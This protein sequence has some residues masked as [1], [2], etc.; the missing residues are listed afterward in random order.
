MVEPLGEQMDV[1][2][3]TTGGTPVVFRVPAHP[4]IDQDRALEL[5]VDTGRL[6]LFEPGEFGASLRGSG[7]DADAVGAATSGGSDG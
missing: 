2:G 1:H 3:D 4:G 7:R 5:V 6:R